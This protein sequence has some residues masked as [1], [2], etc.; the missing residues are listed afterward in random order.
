MDIQPTRS[1]PLGVDPKAVEAARPASA[2]SKASAERSPSGGTDVDRVELS[3][4]A[5][6]RAGEPQDSV[7]ERARETLRDWPTLDPE[8][9]EMIRARL[10]EGAYRQPDSLKQLATTVLADLSGT[11]PDARTP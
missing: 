8:R 2:S 11:T 5:L 3:P 9:M 4:E 6:A 7:L 10:E 1:S